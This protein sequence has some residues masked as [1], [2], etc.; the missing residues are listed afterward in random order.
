[1]TTN[2][3]GILVLAAASAAA[4]LPARAQETPAPPP[5]QVTIRPGLTVTD[6]DAFAVY[7]DST[8]VN[9]RGSFAGIEVWIVTDAGP[10]RLTVCDDLIVDC[11][12]L[13][14]R[15][16]GVNQGDGFALVGE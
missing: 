11:A 13:H 4:I 2:R 7:V 3:I 6:Q 1:M 14:V 10:Q 5:K 9:D 8:V 12:P 15:M 16:E